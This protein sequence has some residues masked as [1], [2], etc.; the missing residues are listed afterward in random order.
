M[1]I[2]LV[3]CLVYQIGILI[4]DRVQNLC[5]LLQGACCQIT[6]IQYSGK[7]KHSALTV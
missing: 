3:Q 4:A 1:L 2:M 7:K 6:V 5:V